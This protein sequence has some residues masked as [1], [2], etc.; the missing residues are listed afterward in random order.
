MISCTLTQCN[1][2]ILQKNYLAAEKA[3]RLEQLAQHIAGLPADP[4][5]T[6]FLA[7]RVRLDDFTP[8]LLHL[9]LAETRSLI[10]S[11]LVRTSPYIVSLEQFVDWHAA[12]ARQRNQ[13]FNAEFRL[14][15]IDNNDEIE[16]LGHKILILP[17]DWPATAASIAAQLPPAEVRQLT[18]TSR[19]GR[20]SQ[21]TNVALALRWLAARGKLAVENVSDN[22]QEAELAYAPFGRRYPDIDLSQPPPEAEAQKAVVRAYLAAFGPAT[23]ADISFWTGFGKSETA[24]AVSALSGETMLA[25]VQGLP[26]MLLMLKNQADALRAV[27]PPARPVV[28]ILPANDPFITAHRA[29][30]NRYFNDQ[31]LQRH[32]FNSSGA[33]KPTIV[34]NGQVAGEWQLE[35]DQNRLTWRLLIHVDPQIEGQI[36][37]ELERAANFIRPNICV[38]RLDS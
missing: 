20:V 14:W 3:A 16:R 38:G 33:A 25:M 6:P 34:V 28:N 24:R 10:K 13:A 35:N 15:G 19:G 7:A 17:G 26:G 32:I 23:E 4:P 11:E 31:K 27:Q 18:Q 29:S 30:R 22:W 36:E 37:T 1:H 12:T 8:D 2:F 9:A 5:A 21:T